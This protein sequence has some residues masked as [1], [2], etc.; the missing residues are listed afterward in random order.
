ME[1]NKITIELLHEKHIEDGLKALENP[2]TNTED[3]I[4]LEDLPY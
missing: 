3:L 1:L 4:N 2:R